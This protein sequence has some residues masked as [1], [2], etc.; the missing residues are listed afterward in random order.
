MKIID[1]EKKYESLYMVCLEDWSDEMKE[2][3]NHKC[4]WYEKMKDKG[5]GVKLAIDDKEQVIGMIQYVPIEYSPA[6]GEGLYFVDCIWVHGHKDGVGNQQKQGAGWQLLQAAEEDIKEKG[7]LGLVVWGLKMPIWMK[8]S[9]FKHQGY[10]TIDKAGM[11]LLLWKPFSPHAKKPHWVKQKVK[12][13]GAGEHPGQVTVM[14]FY[15]G[16]CQ[17]PCIALERTRQ[18]C[19]TFDDEVVFIP[20]D[21]FDRKVFMKWGITDGI[22][23]E[24]KNLSNGPPLSK[25]KIKKHIEKEIKKL[26]KR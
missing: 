23:V 9:W 22:F 21:T 1:L 6:M 10:K 8:A 14:A 20:V 5:L 12:E 13:P 3:G 4:T 15:N 11:A 19:E 25:D 26:N 7:G 16:R 18:V 24:G 17:V 2:A